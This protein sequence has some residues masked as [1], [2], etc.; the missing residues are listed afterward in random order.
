MNEKNTKYNPI[1]TSEKGFGAIAKMDWINLYSSS[2]PKYKVVDSDTQKIIAAE[3]LD[4]AS[5]KGAKTENVDTILNDL[6]SLVNVH[7]FS[8]LASITDI[9]MFSLF[10]DQ[11][12]AEKFINSYGIYADTYSPFY[13]VDK[14]G[15][16]QR[17]DDD[18]LF[19][20]E[21][22][23]WGFDYTY[24]C[25][26]TLLVYFCHQGAS[27]LINISQHRPVSNSAL[28]F[29]VNNLVFVDEISSIYHDHIEENFKTYLNRKENQKTT[30]KTF[31]NSYLENAF[32]DF[33]DTNYKQINNELNTAYLKLLDRKIKGTINDLLNEIHPRL[34]RVN[35]NVEYLC[36]ATSN[37]FSLCAYQIGLFM[38]YSSQTDHDE[39]KKITKLCDECG[40]PFIASHGREIYCSSCKIHIKAICA[41]KLKE[42]KK[43]IES[44]LIDK[45]KKEGEQN[46]T[47]N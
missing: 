24:F 38:C 26:S 47:S 22:S 8:V 10:I 13:F 40:N 46:G 16:Y 11:E 12:R 35:N 44:A 23:Y 41:R 27:Q 5:K 2:G 33:V 37:I 28:L 9:N 14:N 42:K 29:I 3:Y 1:R 18:N 43:A 30:I 39:K 45:E 31:D 4:Y 32:T 7:D 6:I 36:Q 19:E 17:G 34:V 20:M 15:L 21:S 25:L